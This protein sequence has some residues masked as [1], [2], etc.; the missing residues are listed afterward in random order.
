MVPV[1]LVL[2]SMY[3]IFLMLSN[4][5]EREGGMEAWKDGHL[6]RDRDGENENE[7]DQ[8]RITE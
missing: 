7:R 4:H 2:T 8:E 3:H 6:D 5:D 1:V